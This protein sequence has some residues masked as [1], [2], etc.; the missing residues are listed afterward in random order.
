MDSE[1]PGI[2]ASI[3]EEKHESKTPTCNID[4]K[5]QPRPTNPC[6]YVSRWPPPEQKY[7]DR[8]REQWRIK[9]EEE[10]RKT[11]S[12]NGGTGGRNDTTNI[13]QAYKGQC[14]NDQTK[15]YTERQVM[16]GTQ[17]IQSLLPKAKN[18]KRGHTMGQQ[19]SYSQ[20]TKESSIRSSPPWTP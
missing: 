1:S 20:L 5:Y 16:K 2:L 6:D 18:T 19:N 12:P 7:T 9:D 3:Q 17:T 11:N 10:N 15:G 13:A 8:E 4:V 14:D